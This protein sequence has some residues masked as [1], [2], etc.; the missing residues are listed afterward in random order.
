R[1]RT[2]PRKGGGVARGRIVLEHEIRVR[3]LEV[4]L[5]IVHEREGSRRRTGQKCEHTNVEQNSATAVHLSLPLVEARRPSH[6]S[7][8][9]IVEWGN[10]PRRT[11]RR[12]VPAYQAEFL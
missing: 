6:P 5:E 12:I 4:D 11:A 1:T 7:G 8:R 2:E 3:Q 10:K 9:A